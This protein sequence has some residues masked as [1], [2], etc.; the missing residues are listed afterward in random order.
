[1]LT[2]NYLKNQFRVQSNLQQ[3]KLRFLGV[4]LTKEVEVLYTNYRELLK[5]RDKEVGT[6]IFH[7]LSSKSKGFISLLVYS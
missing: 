1:M 6:F 4:N 2:T 5:V 3:L 7:F